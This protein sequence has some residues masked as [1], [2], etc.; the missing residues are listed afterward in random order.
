VR[1]IERAFVATNNDVLLA[2][3]AGGLREYLCSR[4]VD[5]ARFADIRAMVPVGRHPRGE[6]AISG[7]RVVM[8]VVTLPVDEPDPVSR[9][10]RV[11]ATTRDLKQ[12]GTAEGGELLAHTSPALIAGALRLAVWRRAFNT[13]VT[14]VP[15]PHDAMWLLDARVVRVVPIVNLWPHVALGI[16]SATYAGTMSFS[17]HADFDVITDA[18]RLRDDLARA[19]DALVTAPRGATR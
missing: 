2:T 14:N 8:L 19:F 1:A 9:L 3:V 17:V 18:T 10:V 15:G 4:G 11:S 16:A 7:N 6:R 12:R 5:P 13:V